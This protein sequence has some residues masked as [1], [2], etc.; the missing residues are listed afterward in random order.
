MNCKKCY[1]DTD[2][3]ILCSSCSDEILKL[4]LVDK[5][6]A[7]EIEKRFS[8]LPNTVSFWYNY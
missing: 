6:S 3:D 8:L 7:D 4:Y 1:K 2:G 5:V